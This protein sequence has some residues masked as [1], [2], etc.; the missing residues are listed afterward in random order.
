MKTGMNEGLRKPYR[1]WFG[2]YEG[3]LL[4]RVFLF[5]PAYALWLRNTLNKPS[6]QNIVKHIDWCIAELDEK[7]IQ[8]KC[9]ACR[10]PATRFSVFVGDWNPWPF[11][12]KC[13]PFAGGADPSKIIVFD[14][15]EEMLKI[16]QHY[17]SHT[18]RDV[19]K[20][21]QGV[22][23]AK[24]FSKPRTEKKIIEF[25]HDGVGLDNELH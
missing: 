8:T 14:K 7:K 5:Y 2:L 19:R 3:Q 6:T 18:K 17:P 12:D 9:T 20:I 11:C 13:D 24:G 1:M 10:R 21:V 16:L 25:F 23:Y 15:V 4:E 22:A